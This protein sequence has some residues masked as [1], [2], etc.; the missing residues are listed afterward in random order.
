MITLSGAGASPFAGHWISPTR[1]A[2]GGQMVAPQPELA[3][4]CAGGFDKLASTA[5]AELNP[6]KPYG[7]G[8]IELSI[9][10]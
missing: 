9:T 7:A 3:A 6:V 4:E 5:A 8:R 2:G 10:K 1:R